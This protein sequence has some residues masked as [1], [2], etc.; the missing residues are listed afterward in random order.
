MTAARRPS[1][2][3]RKLVLPTW[4]KL[5]HTVSEDGEKFTTA[6]KISFPIS[7]KLQFFLLQRLW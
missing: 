2:Q 7:R 6:V 1:F 5:S 3:K 4:L